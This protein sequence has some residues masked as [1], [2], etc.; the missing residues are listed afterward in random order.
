M[1]ASHFLKKTGP[2]T[3]QNTHSH[4]QY[5]Y[6]HHHHHHDARIY[7]Q[8]QKIKKSIQETEA[9]AP[10]VWPSASPAF[11]YCSCFGSCNPSCPSSLANCFSVKLP[12]HAQSH[13]PRNH[14]SH[15]GLDRSPH[16]DSTVSFWIS[17]PWSICTGIRLPLPLE[18]RK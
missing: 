10:A 4:R 5:K 2:T 3:A 12:C 7:S 14:F 8:R 17:L 13:N 1:C 9:S 18:E 6:H 11:L 16:L 15:F